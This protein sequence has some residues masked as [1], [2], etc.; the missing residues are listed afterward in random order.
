MTRR[1][2][3]VSV[4]I[5]ML[6]VAI[7]S[8]M[9]LLGI[10][11]FLENTLEALVFGLVVA[12]TVVLLLNE[13]RFQQEEHKEMTLRLPSKVFTDK[14]VSILKK[15]LSGEKYDT[16]ARDTGQSINTLKKHVRRLFN[17]LQV[18][19]RTSFMSLYAKHQVILDSSDKA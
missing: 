8:Q 14:D 7:I 17:M 4:I 11:V 10:T 13:W 2:I 5:I 9:L 18:S 19:D 3:K 15:I 16:I 1:R 12:I 6:L